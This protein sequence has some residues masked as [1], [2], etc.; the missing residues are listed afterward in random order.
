MCSGGDHSLRKKQAETGS[1]R[2]HIYLQEPSKGKRR[3]LLMSWSPGRPSKDIRYST[4]KAAVDAATL[5]ESLVPAR[6]LS[7]T[8]TFQ[9]VFFMS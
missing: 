5:K 3:A 4:Q 8:Y 6:N 7:T 9:Y 1:W 2:Q